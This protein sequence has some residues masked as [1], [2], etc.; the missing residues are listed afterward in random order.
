LCTADWFGISAFTR[1]FDALLRQR[2]RAGL[3]APHS[4]FTRVFDT[5][6]RWQMRGSGTATF[7]DPDDYA[8]SISDARINLVLTGHGEFK[9]R[10]TWVKLAHLHLLHGRENLARVA[11]VSPAPESIFV[12][13][14]TGFRPPPTWNGL[15]LQPGD[16]MLCGRGL[17]QWSAGPAQWG[18]IS[19]APERLAAISKT[20]NGLELTVPTAA[21]LLRSPAKA[22]TKL[23][24]LH[25]QAC[26]LAETSPEIISSR[27][28]GRA[29]EDE[30]SQTLVNCL[31][32]ASCEDDAAT[33]NHAGIMARFESV[34]AAHGDRPLS[35]RELC[36]AVGASER[37]LRVCCVEFL[38]MAP[39]RYIR[40]RRLNRVRTALRRAD[41]ATA[42]VASIAR[43]HGFSELGRFAAAYRVAF[44]E[45]P[46]ATLRGRLSHFRDL[47]SA[48]FA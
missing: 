38:G 10:L 2:V 8:A 40:L 20:L 43:E 30:L 47:A 7:G 48:E 21:H 25:A 27:Q 16:I 6:G 26:R 15:Q 3:D 33:K 1:V 19:L 44:G 41:A 5:T 45:T 39:N 42:S 35:M 24:R 34:L 29:L 18:A 4:A 9:A 23:M 12:A 17:H 32:A 28:V 36:T 22:R 31:T 14:P 11:Y 46:S 13:F 37:T